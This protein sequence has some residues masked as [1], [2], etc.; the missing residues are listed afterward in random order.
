MRLV[1]YLMATA[2]AALATGVDASPP[3]FAVGDAN[4]LWI[5]R[6][7]DDSR[8]EVLHRVARDE[9]GVLRPAIES[10]GK[11]IAATGTG[12]RLDLFYEGGIAQSITIRIDPQVGLP[13]FD[14]AQLPSLPDDVRIL[15][16][17]ASDDGPILLIARPH[18]TQTDT[19]AFELLTYGGTSW[20]AT[21]LPQAFDGKRSC[22][23]I[24]EP[25]GP[26]IFMHTPT[27]MIVFDQREGAWRETRIDHDFAQTFAAVMAW[28]QRVIVEQPG[29]ESPLH[30]SV[31]DQ[32]S[33]IPAGTI[34][35]PTDAVAPWHATSYADRAS[36]VVIGDE[37][38]VLQRDLRRPAQSDAIV[39]TYAIQRW[40]GW[41]ANQRLISYGLFFVLL[42]TMVLALRPGNRPQKIALPG[43]LTVAPLSRRGSAALIDLIPSIIITMVILKITNPI[44]ILGPWLSFTDNWAAKTPAVMVVVITGLH[45]LCMELAGRP[46]LGKLLMGCRVVDYTGGPINVAQVIARNGIKLLEL[47]LWPL[48]ITIVLS[49]ARQRMGDQAARTLVVVSHTPAEQSPPTEEG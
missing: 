33:F 38:T 29:P 15:A 25:A 27:S 34:D 14:V 30:V 11:P 21:A 16:T 43:T 49:P 8:F 7:Y 17:A 48:L 26:T 47:L 3:A 6:V 9:P 31:I 45:T 12:G 18:E 20:K 36:V 46:S 5:V 13:A 10:A 40:P 35:L 39:Q 1:L 24:H 41:I 23:L 28:N 32:A 2:L 44:A 42:V 19:T 22:A 37:V 4:G